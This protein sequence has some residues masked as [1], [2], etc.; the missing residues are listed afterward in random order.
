M[1]EANALSPSFFLIVTYSHSPSHTY[2]SYTWRTHKIYDIV[3]VVIF[4]TVDIIS[5]T[6][7]FYIAFILG[8][9]TCTKKI[10]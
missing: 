3:H 5:D 4:K 2:T 1:E 9:C 10:L 6:E 7:V 8:T